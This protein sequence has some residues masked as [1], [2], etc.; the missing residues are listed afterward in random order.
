MIGVAR[1]SRSTPKPMPFMMFGRTTTTTYVSAAANS[2][3]TDASPSRHRSSRPTADDAD[4]SE[5][6]SPPEEA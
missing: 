1:C 5:M 4:A 6:V 3:P 2:T